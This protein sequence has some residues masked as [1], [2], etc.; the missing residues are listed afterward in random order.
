MYYLI[1]QFIPYIRVVYEQSMCIDTRPLHASIFVYINT[2]RIFVVYLF[3]KQNNHFI[4]NHSNFFLPPSTPICSS[5]PL[6]H[7]YFRHYAITPT[8]PSAAAGGAVAAADFTA[9]STAPLCRENR[10]RHPKLRTESTEHIPGKEQQ[11]TS[12]KKKSKKKNTH[13][14]DV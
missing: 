4:S 2:V 14:H 8:L 7:F 6:N 11:Q 13:T 3:G 9:T 10:K 5:C 12:K 1:L